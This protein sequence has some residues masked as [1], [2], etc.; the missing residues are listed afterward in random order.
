MFIYF[1]YESQSGLSTPL[2]FTLRLSLSLSRK[3]THFRT[4]PVDICSHIF[5]LS[6]SLHST[7][8]S[9]TIYSCYFEQQRCTGA[10]LSVCISEIVAVVPA[11]RRLRPILTI[12]P[13]LSNL[14]QLSQP[15]EVTAPVCLTLT[16]THIMYQP[17]VTNTNLVAPL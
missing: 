13:T 7:E 6:V 1:S 14:Q 17:T 11:L 9:H 3:R 8:F 10:T 12:A 5:S 15:H 4:Y 16:Q 2:S